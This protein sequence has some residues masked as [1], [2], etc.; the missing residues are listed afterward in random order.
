MKTTRIAYLGMLTAG[1]ALFFFTVPIRLG[2][3]Q[4]AVVHIDNDDIGGVVTGANGPE[5]GV[6]VVAETRDLPTR[7]AKMVVTDDQGRYLLPDLPKATYS[8]WVRGYGLVDS[9]KVQTARGKVLNLKA[10]LAPN[11]AAAAE[12]YPPIYWFSMLNVPGKDLFPGTGPQG[13]GIA[14]NQRT[15]YDWLNNLKSNGCYGCH[16]VGNKATRTISKVWG[17]GDTSLNI[18]MRRMLVG[19]GGESMLSQINRLGPDR[20]LALFADWSDRIAAGELPATKPLRPEGVERNVVVTVWEWSNPKAYMHDEIATDKRKPTVNAYGKL[21]GAPEYSTDKIPV[22]DPV[23]NTAI[24]MKMPV[25]DP[26]TPSSKEDPIHAPSM[27]WGEERLWDSQTV[28]HNPMFDDKGRVWFTSRIRPRDNPAFCKKGS[29]HPAAKLTPVDNSGRQLSMYDPKSGKFTLINTCYGTHHLIF[30]EDANNTLWTSGGGGAGVVGWFN[31]KMFEETGD[32]EKSQGWTA[33]ILD[34]NGN[35]KRD[36]YVGPKDPVDPT[37]DKQLMASFYGVA[38]SPVDGSIWGSIRVFPG[39]VVR[40]N[41][42]PNPPHTALAEVYELPWK[43]GKPLAHG[44]GP[45]GMDIDRNG[46][47]WTVL[48]SGHLASFDRRKCQGPLNGPSATGQ[49]CPEGWTMYPFPGPQFQ[50]LQDPGSAESAYY[51][52]VDQFNTLGLG[53]NVPIAT[54]NANDAMLALVDGKFVILRV[55][56]PMGFFAKGLDGRI[57]DPKAGWKGRGVWSTF[58]SRVPFHMEGGKGMRPNVVKWQ[59]RPDPLAK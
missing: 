41:P 27:V 47:V 45:R 6:W 25:R 29:E 16:Q 8:V 37:K 48:S 58:G 3:Q 4:N 56:F 13:N 39:Q 17:H 44:Y 51:V 40:L 59:I 22:L 55:A 5:A 2:G 28:P 11:A 50:N 12:Y 36:E 32:E 53:E 38:Y 26:K 1:V 34:T 52:W 31:T 24:E 35:G 43:D 49:H 15:Q 18:W 23:R 57:D 20:T 33:L 14:T 42:G 10:V 7:F 9:R 46:V 30:A 19:Q 21:Y 54:G